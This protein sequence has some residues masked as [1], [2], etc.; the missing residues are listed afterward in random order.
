MIVSVSHASNK[1]FLVVEE[2]LS[3]VL[4]TMPHTCHRQ[5]LSQ[6]THVRMYTPYEILHLLAGRLHVD[7]RSTARTAA[8]SLI[9]HVFTGRC[10]CKKEVLPPPA[11]GHHHCT[12]RSSCFWPCFICKACHRTYSDCN[13]NH[14]HLPAGCFL[15]VRK[16]MLLSCLHSWHRVRSPP[17]E[18]WTTKGT[19]P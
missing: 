8:R 4:A 2:C 14:E 1:Q 17:C 12:G 19:R 11:H 10:M 13:N 5:P 18:W 3:L 9:N 6:H 16:V 15:P 7:A